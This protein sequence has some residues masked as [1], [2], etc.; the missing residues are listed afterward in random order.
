MRLYII[1]NVCNISASAT[2]IQPTNMPT[3][4]PYIAIII[5]P[6]ILLTGTLGIFAK[7]PDYM[8]YQAL[9]IY[10]LPPHHIS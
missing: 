8:P 1:G 6:Q 2:A 7:A 3:H 10:Y 9:M 4:S 5:F